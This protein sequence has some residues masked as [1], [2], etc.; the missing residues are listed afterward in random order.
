[1]KGVTFDAGALVA[2]ERGD[3]RIRALLRLVDRVTIPSG[4]LAQ[5]WRTG[6]GRQA[7]IARLIADRDATEI[8]GL[9]EEEARA[10]GR[11]IA[12]CAHPDIVDVH[13]ALC[14]RRRGQRVVTSDPED[15]ARADPGLQIVPL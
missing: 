5:V 14:A 8:V 11:R 2:L 12:Q 6:T 7:A 13:V 3:G 4:V 15:I 1:M 10:V 9:D